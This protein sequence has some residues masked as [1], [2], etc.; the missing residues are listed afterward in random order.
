MSLLL[1]SFIIGLPI[2][3]YPKKGLRTEMDLPHWRERTYV[4]TCLHDLAKFSSKPV[5]KCA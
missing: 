1:P 3:R 5:H 4:T 2:V